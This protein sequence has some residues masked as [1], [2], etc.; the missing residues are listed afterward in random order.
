MSRQR[1]ARPC[2]DRGDQARLRAPRPR[3][4]RFRN[5]DAGFRRAAVAG[6]VAGRGRPHRHAPRRALAAAA[7]A[8]RHDLDGA[9]S[10][11]E[12]VAVSYIQSI[13]WEYGSGVVLPRTGVLM[14]NRGIA[15]SLDPASP[16]RAEARTP[17]VPHAE[18][19]AGRVRRRP[20]DV[21]RLD[22]RRRAAAIPGAGVQPHRRRAVAGARGRGAALAVGPHLGRRQRHGQG[23]GRLRRRGRR[24]PRP[25]R[26]RDRAPP[27]EARQTRSATPARCGAASRAR[28]RRPTIPAPTAARWA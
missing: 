16:A 28:S 20:R 14:Q 18:P 17:A 21:L 10:T 9:R 3:L 26:P 4:R 2:A 24:R 23:R 11:R 25:A 1:R 7:R 22:G 8:G 15:F 13:Y 5:R 12:G 19:G 6:L 27:P